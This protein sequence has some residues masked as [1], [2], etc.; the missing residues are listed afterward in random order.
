MV[1]V[2]V[3]R[4]R[5]GKALPSFGEDGG[6]AVCCNQCKT[7]QMVDVRRKKCRCGKARPNFGEA[8]GKA[9]C[10]NQ[11][12]TPEMVSGRNKSSS[13]KL[14]AHSRR[15]KLENNESNVVEYLAWYYRQLL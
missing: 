13:S 14:P 10:C 11:C 5:C 3:K 9:V 12:K 7:P 6:K 4:W 8:G 15:T 1:N 2:S